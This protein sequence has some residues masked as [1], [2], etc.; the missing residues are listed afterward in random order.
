M[1]T[2]HT[3]SFLVVSP[4]PPMTNKLMLYMHTCFYF[5]VEDTE[6]CLVPTRYSAYEPFWCSKNPVGWILRNFFRLGVESGFALRQ[7]ARQL[8]F[9][10]SCNT[11]SHGVWIDG[12]WTWEQR[13]VVPSSSK[14]P[15]KENFLS[16]GYRN[17]ILSFIFFFPSMRSKILLTLCFTNDTA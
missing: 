7:P 11:S 16:L 5:Y 9:W 10:L 13:T 1:Y 3:S 15:F 2:T 6:L 4:V 12:P 17:T 8:V 14:S